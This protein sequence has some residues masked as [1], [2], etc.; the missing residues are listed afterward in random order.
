MIRRP[1]RSTLFP[2]T[3]LFRSQSTTGGCGLALGTQL[4]MKR[5]L[6][7][8]NPMAS[9]HDPGVPRIVS[10]TLASLGVEVDVA[11]TTRHGDAARIA[12]QGVADR[13]DAV[14]V[15]GGDG[16]TMQAV[17]GMI[18]AGIPL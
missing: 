3:T 18:G 15:Y 12:A 13:V 8:T 2:Y 4:L 1:P 5:V 16:T 6:L 11:G 10:S 17:S 14:A 7:I 9:R